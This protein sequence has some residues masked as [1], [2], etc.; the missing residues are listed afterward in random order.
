MLSNFFI[1]IR[2][3]IYFCINGKY[4]T[5]TMTKKKKQKLIKYIYLKNFYFFF[6][7]GNINA[8]PTGLFLRE[9]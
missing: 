7:R 1:F 4:N 8:Y 9:R 6:Q 2:K 5:N 3:K